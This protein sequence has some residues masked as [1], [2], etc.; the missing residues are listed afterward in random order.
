MSVRVSY[1]LF[2]K[3]LNKEIKEQIE[4]GWSYEIKS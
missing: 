2:S 3:I 1:L 4:S